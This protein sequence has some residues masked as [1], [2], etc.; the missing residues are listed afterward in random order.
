MI[1]K[2]SQLLGI[3]IVFIIAY[4]LVWL[5]FEF[6]FLAIPLWII[7]YII[8]KR[9]GIISKGYAINKKLPKKQL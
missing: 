9:S 7:G 1:H 5:L 6:W 4:S 2:F 8:Y 3:I